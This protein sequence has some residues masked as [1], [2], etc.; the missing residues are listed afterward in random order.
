MIWLLK[1]KPSK[2]LIGPTPLTDLLDRPG[3][4][5]VNLTHMIIIYTTVG[6]NPLEEME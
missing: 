5:W 3:L 2:L 1:K 4:E 6:R